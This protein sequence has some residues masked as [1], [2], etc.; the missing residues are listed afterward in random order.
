MKTTFL[1]ILSL[2]LVTGPLPGNPDPP[3][4]LS[5]ESIISRYKNSTD[6]PPEWGHYKKWSTDALLMGNGDMGLSVGGEAES[7]RFWINKNDFWRLQNQHLGAQPKLFG[8]L[9]LKVPAMQGAT[10]KIEQP[11]YNPVTH[12]TFTK[13]GAT[14]EFRARVMAT[15]N[16]GWIEL[17]A[18]GKPVE[19]EITTQLTDLASRRRGGVRVW[20]TISSG[21][22]GTTMTTLTSSPAW[23]R[24]CGSSTIRAGR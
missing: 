14:L 12:G 11:I 21:C 16:L 6:K 8:W 20:L 10:Y 2:L 17:E 13:D 5:A 3:E 4:P 1:G 9:D 24:R 23:P 7:L 15:T 18:S 19:I 22:S